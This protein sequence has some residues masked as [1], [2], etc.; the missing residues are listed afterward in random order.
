M[1]HLRSNTSRPNIHPAFFFL[2]ADG[3]RYKEQ[4]YSLQGLIFP[5]I[6]KFPLPNK[7][8]LPL[9]SDYSFPKSALLLR[10]YTS[11]PYS[12]ICFAT[13]LNC[14]SQCCLSHVPVAISWSLHFLDHLHSQ[15]VADDVVDLSHVLTVDSSQIGY[16]PAL[17]NCPDLLQFHH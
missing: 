17:I 15:G 1:L 10:S 7:L 3:F 8:L 5:V 12:T 16:D 14:S 9:M 6:Y 2:V 11:S 4:R 13:S